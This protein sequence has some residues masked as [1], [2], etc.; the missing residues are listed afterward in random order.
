MFQKGIKSLLGGA[1]S[2]IPNHFTG[3]I[4]I[5]QITLNELL[6]HLKDFGADVIRSTH[7]SGAIN[8]P[9]G[10]HLKTRA[11]VSKSDV[12]ILVNE[13]VV[14]F[15]VPTH[16]RQTRHHRKVNQ[17]RGKEGYST[18]GMALLPPHLLIYPPQTHLSCT[19]MHVYVLSH[20]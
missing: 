20:K 12:A 6:G 11:K 3:R 2:H 15:N 13:N 10:I 1:Y 19:C 17:Q 16:K 18:D 5:A 14:W 8:F 9:V 4:P 7:S